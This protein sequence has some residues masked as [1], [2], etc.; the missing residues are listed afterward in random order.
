MPRRCS[1]RVIGTGPG[2]FAGRAQAFFSPRPCTGGR[3][4]K[5]APGTGDLMAL[6][7]SLENLGHFAHFAFRSLTALPFV[8]LRRPG[9]LLHQLYQIFLGALPLAVAGGIAV[10]AVIWMHGRP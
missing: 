10:G 7:R 2:R 3:G 9:A 8:L 4:E 6:L 1:R 5:E